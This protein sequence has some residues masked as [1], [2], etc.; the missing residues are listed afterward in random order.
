MIRVSLIIGAAAAFSWSM[1]YLVIEY[2][3]FAD[4]ALIRQTIEIASLGLTGVFIVL[5]LGRLILDLV[6][7][8]L[9]HMSPTGIG[10]ALIYVVLAVG[11]SIPILAYFGINLGTL[12]TTSAILGALLGLTLQQPLHNFIAGLALSSDR[13]LEV[14]TTLV[15]RGQVMEVT[16]RTWRHV[17]TR[18]PDNTMS[19]IPNTTLANEPL[20]ILP[21]DRPTRCEITVELPWDVPPELVTARLRDACADIADVDASQP[22][23]VVPFQARPEHNALAYRVRAWVRQYDDAGRIEGE[24]LRR[25][26]YVLNRAGIRLPESQL[27]QGVADP[28]PDVRTQMRRILPNASEEDLDRACAVT[29]RYRFAA[30]EKLAFSA[31]HVGETMLVLEGSACTRDTEYLTLMEYGRTARKY[32][33]RLEAEEIPNQAR[34]SAVADILAEEIGPMAEKLVQE[35]VTSSQDMADLISRL[36]P[37]TSSV[38]SVERLQSVIRGKC[39]GT[40]NPGAVMILQG[41]VSGHAVPPQ[42][43]GALSEFTVAVLPVNELPE[44]APS[45]K[46]ELAA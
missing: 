32:L 36:R 41:E 1:H 38:E 40:I 27:F 16:G 42:T 2:G 23:V 35:E 39:V 15:Y 22:V 9:L 29:K 34:L 25:A 45:P 20:T 7:G 26:W 21:E 12:L 37:Y 3:L 13:L 19:A 17:V 33:P 4:M 30:G 24:M 8:D 31:A 44:A 14:G 18:H 46:G 5:V 43:L 10:K 11:V 28:T 6:L